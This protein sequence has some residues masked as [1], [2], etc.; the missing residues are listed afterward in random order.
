MLSIRPTTCSWATWQPATRPRRSISTD[1]GHADVVDGRC[2]RRRS[3]P[4]PGGTGGPAGSRMPFLV[5]LGG[6]RG[7]GADD[8]P[9]HVH[10]VG[11]DADPGR[12]DRPRRKIGCWIMTSWGCRPPPWCGSLAKNTSPGGHGVAEARDG[13]L[14]RVRRRAEM[15]QDHAGAD[16]QVALRIDEGDREVLG[17]GDGR[18]DRGVLDA[19]AAACSPIASSRLRQTSRSIGSVAG[20]PLPCVAVVGASAVV[21]IV[22]P[23]WSWFSSCYFH[24]ERA[25]LVDPGAAA[26]GNPDRGVHGID[27][28]RHR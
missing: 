2:P 3:S 20:R 5:A 8:H 9:A 19:P 11:R 27:Q 22:R 10:H 7:E 4:R 24:D 25:V 14:D 16:D 23:P 12:P 26:L 21:V 6:L 13:R 1:V 17:L 18:R 15:E 28:R